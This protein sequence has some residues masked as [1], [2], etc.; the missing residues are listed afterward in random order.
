[1]VGERA[2]AVLPGDQPST[3]PAQPNVGLAPVVSAASLGMRIDERRV[4]DE[5]DLDISPGD[6]VALLGANGAGKSTLLRI[7]AT[8]SPPTSGT[9]RLFGHAVGRD[10]ARLRARIGMVG[11]QLMLYRELTAREN[12]EFFGRLYAVERVRERALELLEFVG[13]A[14]RADDPV[15]ALSRGM[16]QRVAIA[17]AFMH[18][19]ALLLTD[20][21]FT[22][23]DV[24]SIERLE[25]CLTDLHAE[26]R[27]ILMTTHDIDQG[28]RLARRIVVLRRGRIV[29]D[30][31]SH[32]LDRALVAGAMGASA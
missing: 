15:K 6:C 20:E 16:A 7:V 30:Q 22:G 4:L 24:H 18:S 25:R 21:P 23:L 9:L 14:D 13:L 17:R 28:L 32:R 1:M 2:M 10:A 19:P 8:L 27:T 11:H 3:P 31:P 26:G 29:L 12:L 5:I